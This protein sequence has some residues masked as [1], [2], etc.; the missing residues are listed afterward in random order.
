L[1]VKLS[2]SN[3]LGYLQKVGICLQNVAASDKYRESNEV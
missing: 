1:R 2:I 3:I